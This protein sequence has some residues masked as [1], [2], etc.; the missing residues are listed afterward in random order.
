MDLLIQNFKTNKK[1]LIFSGLWIMVTFLF[2]NTTYNMLSNIGSAYIQ[3]FG[4]FFGSI[5]SII[6]TIGYFAPVLMYNCTILIFAS[7]YPNA[8]IYI[9]TKT[10]A[11]ALV[12]GIIAGI[13]W[14]AS[15]SFLCL[16]IL[17]YAPE[18]LQSFIGGDLKLFSPDK[19][20]FS[21]QLK[22]HMPTDNLFYS[23]VSIIPFGLSFGLV[24]IMSVA[25]TFAKIFPIS[26]ILI[27]GLAVYLKFR[28]RPVA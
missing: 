6:F 2:W 10:K 4:E 23:L 19:L 3:E 20:F 27:L 16:V 26:T 7:L 5:M 1:I 8:N 28:V 14:L 25:A 17:L 24:R 11:R 22:L 21:S 9:F 18:T 15:C 12:F 13:T